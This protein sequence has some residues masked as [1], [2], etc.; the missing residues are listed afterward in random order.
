MSNCFDC[1]RT[2][3]TEKSEEC[4][5][6]SGSGCGSCVVQL[7]SARFKMLVAAPVTTCERERAEFAPS[8][9]SCHSS[10]DAAAGCQGLLRVLHIP[11][12][13]PPILISVSQVDAYDRRRENLRYIYIYII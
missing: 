11:G 5:N 4:L 9:A 12:F 1:E 13:K 10:G 8:V 3:V 7:T 2:D 6:R